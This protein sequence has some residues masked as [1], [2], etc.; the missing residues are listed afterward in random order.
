MHTTATL[1]AHPA[2][3][4]IRVF[5]VRFL[6]R[7]YGCHFVPSKPKQTAKQSFVPFDPNGG[8]AA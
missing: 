4:P 6:A 7:E 3:N 5:E 1:H 2:C 8:R